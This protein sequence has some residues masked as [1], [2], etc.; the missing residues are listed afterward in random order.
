M[1]YLQTFNRRLRQIREAGQL[2]RW[3]VAQMCGVDEARVVGWE[4]TDARQRGYPGVT[5]LLD[6][7]IKTETPM[8]DLLDLDDSGDTEQLELPGLAFSQGDGLS[9]ALKELEQEISRLQL[10][11]EE[12]ELLRRFRKTSDENRRM[13]LQILGR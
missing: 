12:V 9:A 5:E 1:R 11:E 10:S 8:E 3:D 13:I 4:A 6:L 7:C 2:S